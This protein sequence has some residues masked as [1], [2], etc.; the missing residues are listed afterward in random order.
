LRRRRGQEKADYPHPKLRP[1]L[2]KTLGVPLF[3]EQVMKMAVELA[4]F[5]PGESDQL[6]RAI[7]AWRSQG[8]IEK[9]GE[10]LKAGLRGN[11]LPQEFVERIFLQIQGFAQYGFPESH[12]ASFALIAYV[13]CY[14]KCHRPAEFTCALLN[15]Q[16]MGFYASH[17]L[18]DDV[19]RHGVKVLPVDPNESEWESKLE[20]GAIRLGWKVV[21][22]IHEKEAEKI[23]EGRPYLS[24]PDFLKRTVIR[25]EALVR[26]A[27]GDTFLNFGFAPRDALWQVLEFQRRKDLVQG[28][29]FLDSAYQPGAVSQASFRGLQDHEKINEQYTA[30]SLSTHGHPMMALRKMLPLSK[31]NT[32]SAK[33]RPNGSQVSVAGLI[34]VRQRPP[35]AKG[36]TFSTL[37]DEF[38]FLDVAIA[39]QVWEK[40]MDVFLD[41][42]FL[43]IT[44][45]LQRDT[46]S[47]SLM[48]STLR[49]LWRAKKA[50]DEER[51]FIE[52]TQYFHTF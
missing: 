9:L 42:C 49:P 8:S 3:Q 25:R 26:L 41:N 52:P 7:A 2:G 51:L 15:S 43:E 50:E 29:L 11:G 20:N 31:L 22:G 18:V 6:R 19:K 13:S 14:L 40:V 1:I 39:P 16:P 33:Q 32:Q 36:M 5:T 48:V 38:G 12:A 28:D 35:T 27:M 10:K 21:K 34:L 17:T 4:N 30:F 47:Y 23:I 24:L 45:K 37:E 46:N 44:G